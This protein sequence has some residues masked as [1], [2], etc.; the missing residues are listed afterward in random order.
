[1]KTVSTIGTPRICTCCG[2]PLPKDESTCEYCGVSYTG[3]PP[4][5]ENEV[6]TIKLDNLRTQ[7][8][9][10]MEDLMSEAIRHINMHARMYRR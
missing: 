3:L 4:K 10:E 8:E 7:M 1:M 5:R 6:I 2:G 9:M